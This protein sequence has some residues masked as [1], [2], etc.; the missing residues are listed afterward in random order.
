M[1]IDGNTQPSESMPQPLISFATDTVWASTT[2]PVFYI[3]SFSG[4][5]PALMLAEKIEEIEG[6]TIPLEEALESNL[7]L[8]LYY[9]RL[10]NEAAL[11]MAEEAAEEISAGGMGLA[12]WARSD[13]IEV[14][15]S[16]PFSPASVRQWSASDEAAYRG[17]LGCEGLANA[18]LTAQEF[19]LIGPFTNNG[20]AYLAEIVS[21]T[22]PQIPEERSQLTGFYLSMQSSHNSLYTARLMENMRDQANIVDSR[23]QYYN[24]MDSLRADYAARQEALEE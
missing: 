3:P 17:F 4:S 12:E 2:G 5:Y 16:Q 20:V 10:Q 7:A 24:T 13:S 6:G 1:V 23:E 8:S 21:R 19:T 14:Q 9:S 22:A 18:A 11:R 15:D